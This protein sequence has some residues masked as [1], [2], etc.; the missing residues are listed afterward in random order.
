MRAARVVRLVLALVPAMA[1][2]RAFARPT[3]TV[4]GETRA[5]SSDGARVE[6]GSRGPL[7]AAELQEDQ[8]AALL[9]AEAR[10]GGL[11]ELRAGELDLSDRDI[12]IIL[13]TAA[14]VILLVLIF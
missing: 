12:K 8:R 3:D 9:A 11:E 6:L 2:C 10:A 5:A 14:V 1:G 13:V 4:A 7:A